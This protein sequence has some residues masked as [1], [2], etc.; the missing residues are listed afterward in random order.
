MTIFY[1]KEVNI[2]SNMLNEEE[3]T[4]CFQVLRHQQGD[5]IMVFDGKGTSYSSVLTQVSKKTCLFE[6]IE[7]KHHQKKSFSIHLVISPTKKMDRMEWMIEKLCEIGVDEVTFI[8][9]EHSE[10]RKQRMDRLKK[11]TISAMK[12]SGNPWML[13]LNELVELKKL[14]PMLHSE[15]KYI[16]HVHS[17]GSHLSEIS[18]A[19][20]SVV[21]LIGPEGDFSEREIQEAINEG[22]APVSLGQ[23]TLRTETAGLIACGIINAINRF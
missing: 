5:N 16:A 3:S 2:G 10:G 11:K 15:E 22:F 4:H 1:K 21:L 23:H 18:H 7:T 19:G 12:Q 6:V 20:K 17:N 9:T 14:M 13:K 8:Q